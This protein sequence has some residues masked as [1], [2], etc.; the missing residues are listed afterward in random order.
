MEPVGKKVIRTSR[1]KKY[2]MINSLYM[3]TIK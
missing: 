2:E 1:N 3:L